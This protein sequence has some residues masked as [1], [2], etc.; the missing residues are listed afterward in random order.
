M[1]SQTLIKKVTGRILQGLLPF[2]FLPAL[3]WFLPIMPQALAFEQSATLLE[4]PTLT[5]ADNP[6]ERGLDRLGIEGTRDQAEGTVDEAIGKTQRSVGKV[7]GQTEGALK[8]AEGQTKQAIAKTKESANQVGN[9]AE[10]N[11]E[12][13]IDKIK[14]IFD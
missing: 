1:S 5:I 13:L 11:T 2:C 4:Q 8:E 6:I 7:T 3:I 12:S 14:N 9:K 10:D